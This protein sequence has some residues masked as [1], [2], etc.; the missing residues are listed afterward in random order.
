MIVLFQYNQI[1][2]STHRVIYNGQY[3]DTD[4]LLDTRSTC[5]VFKNGKMLLNVRGSDNILRAY[6]NGGHQISK[7]GVR[8]FLGIFKVWLNMNLMVNILSFSD[9]RKRLRIT[10]YNDVENIIMVHIDKERE[11]KFRQVKP[12]LYL[13]I[14]TNKTN[15]KHISAYSYL[16]L[17]SAKKSSFTKQQLDRADCAREFRRKIG[18]IWYKSRQS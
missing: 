14:N 15:S 8:D 16:N 2:K 18:Y 13:F 1:S 17:V 10:M 11:M 9:V 12:G 6:T 5:S 4:I 7:M 3:I